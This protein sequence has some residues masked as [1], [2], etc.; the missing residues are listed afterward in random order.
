MNPMFFVF[1]AV[2]AGLIGLQFLGKKFS[3]KKMVLLKE[4]LAQGAKVI[5]V[6]SKSEFKAGAHP[7]AQN[8]PLDALA[9]SLKALGQKSQPLVVYCASGARSAQAK[10][11]LEAQGFTDVTNA[12]ALADLLRI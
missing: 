9:K 7:G 10:A 3:G 1:L 6:R 12:G 8:I 5:D 4:K 2:V 11:L